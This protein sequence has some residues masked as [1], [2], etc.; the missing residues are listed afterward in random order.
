MLVYPRLNVRHIAVLLLFSGCAAAT[1]AAAAEPPERISISDNTVTAGALTSGAL[2]VRLDARVGEWHPDRDTDP[3]VVVKAFG[4]NGGPLQIPGPIIRVTEGTE[5]HAYIHNG[6]SGEPLVMH[7][8]YSR[9][10]PSSS[11]DV[12][13]TVP[14]GETR[15]V[16]FTAG[17]AGTYYYWGA[18][19]AATALDQR[20]GPES[21]LAGAL[22]IDPRGGPRQTDRVLVMGFWSN[23]PLPNGGPV[24]SSLRR[25]VINGRS[26][27]H[28]ERLSYNVGDT[29]RVRVIN[30]GANVHPMHLHGFYFNVDSRGNEGQDVVQPPGASP[31]MVVTERLVP[32][33]TFTLTWT[34]TRPG[35]WLFHC[36]DDVH[37]LPGGSLA[38][39]P[40]PAPDHHDVTNHALEGMAGPVMGIAV[41]GASIEDPP[42]AASERRRLRLVARVDAGGTVAEP[43]WGYTL[44]E[45]GKPTLPA[46]APFLPGP[47]L[48]LKRNE[49]VTVTVENRLPEAT[50]VHW[51]GIELESYYDGVPG[52]AGDG[53]RLAPA[54]APGQSFEARFTPPRSGTFIY[55]THVDEVRQK[56]AGL[57]GALLVV[58]DPARHDPE[59]D[60]VMLVTVPRTG[61]EAAKVLINGSLSPV[62]REMH[63]GQH[64]RLRLINAHINRPGMWMRMRR[65]SDILTWRAVAKDGRDLPQDQATDRS[66][67]V[68][69]GNGET[70][71]FDFVPSAQGEI[72]FEVRNAAEGLLAT[73]P[74]RVR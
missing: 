25:F 3:G 37:L 49:P 32:G 73:L 56:Q 64:Y 13:I 36:H 34:P 10:G 11:V 45:P 33:R 22:I 16:R 19:A 54:I 27:P 70:Y 66:A 58:D 44:D 47:T 8:L 1:T 17:Q 50:S 35:N 39:Q 71:D 31:R 2:T 28:T 7:G 4:V 60:L 24:G 6:I 20:L 42:D 63:V 57:T 52:F 62:P 55:H 46:A 61:A 40:T 48:I 30:A 12:P 26:W 68:Q 21:Q 53:Q 41:T 5:I 18:A 23:S 29:V 43:A 15:D 67:E 69:M 65:D 14:P 59:H 72:R 9:T 38:G 51:H 74:I